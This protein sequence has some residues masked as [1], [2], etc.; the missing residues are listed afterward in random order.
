[1]V[2][3]VTTENCHKIALFIELVHRPI[4]ALRHET[5]DGFDGHIDL[6]IDDG[7]FRGFPLAEHEV[8]LATFRIVVAQAEAQAAEYVGAQLLDDVGEAVVAAVGTLLAHAQRAERQGDVVVHH[9]EV[10]NR[11]L[12]LLEPVFHSFSAEVHVSCRLD[13]EQGLAFVSQL[14]GLCEAARS[15]R[16]FEVF[17]QTVGNLEAD[18]VAR[19]VVFSAD[20][21]ETSDEIFHFL[22]LKK[23]RFIQRQR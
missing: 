8:D 4:R 2:F 5:L 21:S 14:R 15:E 17:G 13:D 18:V 7:L 20:V 19:F 9:E 6:F 10:L 22:T 12:L 3:S 11:N 16:A 23:M 1:M